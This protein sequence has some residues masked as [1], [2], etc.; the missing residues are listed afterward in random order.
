MALPRQTKFWAILAG[1]LAY[2]SLAVILIALVNRDPSVSRKQKL[3]QIHGVSLHRNDSGD[4]VGISSNLPNFGDEQLQRFA[5]IIDPS[6]IEA[7]ALITSSVTD[8]GLRELPPMPNLTHLA[9][10][11]SQV[12]DKGVDLI[13]TIAPNVGTLTLSG[14]L[15]SDGSVSA[16]AK[17]AKLEFV[18]LSRTVFGQKGADRLGSALPDVEIEYR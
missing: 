16:L 12:S 10:D 17:L 13:P 14:T 18:D 8:D 3:E 2:V 1:S 4:I 7:I 6:Q 15:V 11:D 9:L 5:E